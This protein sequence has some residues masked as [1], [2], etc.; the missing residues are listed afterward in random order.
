LL[1]G[2]RA[3]GSPGPV[4]RLSTARALQDGRGRVP[5]LPRAAVT[6]RLSSQVSRL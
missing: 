6:R 3:L 4:A 2:S 1:P 5:T